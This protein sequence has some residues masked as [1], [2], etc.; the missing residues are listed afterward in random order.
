MNEW[1]NGRMGGWVNGEKDEGINRLEVI[2]RECVRKK[3]LSFKKQQAVNQTRAQQA[4][5]K[6][7]W[8]C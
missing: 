1:T 6:V 8:M 4:Y 2:C 7:H 5:R 3:N